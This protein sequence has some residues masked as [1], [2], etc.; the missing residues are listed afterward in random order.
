LSDA[1]KEA[2]KRKGRNCQVFKGDG[3]PS[4]HRFAQ[5]LDVIQGENICL[6]VFKPR[7]EDLPGNYAAEREKIK[8]LREVM[9]DIFH[10]HTTHRPVFGEYS[11]TF[12][13]NKPIIKIDGHEFDKV[14]VVFL[15]GCTM[16][17]N[18]LW[19]NEKIDA[20][21]LMEDIRPVMERLHR[22]GYAHMDIKMENV[23]KCTEKPPVKTL[24]TYKLI[25]FG[26]VN[27]KTNCSL[28]AYTEGFCAPVF[29]EAYLRCVHGDSY[30]RDH[31]DGI[32]AKNTNYRDMFNEFAHYEKTNTLN[33]RI[34]ATNPSPGKG[35]YVPISICQYN[36]QY[37]I[38]FMLEELQ[39]TNRDSF[40]EKLM[41]TEGYFLKA[42]DGGRL[43]VTK[44][45]HID[46]LGRRRVL[47]KTSC[48]KQ[49]VRMA[50][51]LV[52]VAELRRRP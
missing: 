20:E 39:A 32:D 52:A 30:V 38:A 9:G 42:Q 34:L 24:P 15:Q 13:F 18:E 37:A 36:D 16:S 10:T 4:N 8:A 1:L 3:N 21:K 50:G 14:N 31:M 11:M 45:G 29:N 7:M 22:K 28:I 33:E 27:Q 2:L 43:H 23:V 51:R 46:L 41:T 48:G 12:D 49:Y 40:V 17:L 19:R 5:V 44:S 25:D 6:K 35:T 47:Y 26:M